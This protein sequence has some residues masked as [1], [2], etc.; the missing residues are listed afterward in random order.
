MSVVE[1]R[2]DVIVVGAGHAGCEAG[3]ATA[4]LGL[5][6]V[7]FTVSA[8]SIAFMPCNPHIG[9]SSKDISSVSWMRSA[10]RWERSSIRLSCSRR[11]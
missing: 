10:V 11:C 8:D 5:E 3:L 6:T 7:V 9:G 4:R 1:E 2:Y